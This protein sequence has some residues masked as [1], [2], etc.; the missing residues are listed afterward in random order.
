MK[1]KNMMRPVFLTL[2][3]AHNSQCMEQTQALQQSQKYKN[4]LEN[5]LAQT[6]AFQ[7]NRELLHQQLNPAEIEK[8]DCI[9]TEKYLLKDFDQYF[10]DVLTD[11]NENTIKSP[12][13]KLCFNIRQFLNDAV[14]ENTKNPLIKECYQYSRQREGGCRICHS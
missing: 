11:I 13:W 6:N 3:Y 7:K 10:L 5:K 12:G 4:V 2:L 8:F 1:I 14:N 9:H